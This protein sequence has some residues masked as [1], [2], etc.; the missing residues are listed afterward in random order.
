MSYSGCNCLITGGLGFLGSNLAHALVARGARVTVIDNFLPLHGANLFNI[1]GIE[2]KIKVVKADIR[3]CP[4]L[5]DIVKE[6]E[7]IFNLA[8]QVSHL[9]SI[10]EPFTDYEINVLGNL[11]ILEACRNAGNSVRII[12]AGT[13]SQY[14]EVKK[15]PV[16][17][18]TQRLPLDIYSV[19][20]DTAE[21]LHFIYGALFGLR[22][23]SLRINN[24]FGPY[25]QMQ[26]HRY[27]ILNWFIRIALEDKELKV[28]GDGAQLRDY[29]FVDDITAAFLIAGE[30]KEAEGEVYNT[31]SGN[32]LKFGEMA[33]KIVKIAGAGRI[34]TVP[35][36]EGYKNI[37][38]GNYRVNI[39]K[40]KALGWKP[41]SD[42]E[43]GLKKTIEFYRKYKNYYW[44]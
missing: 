7:V 20:K 10:S 30:K 39:S 26:H 31:G 22:V 38:V 23:T 40:L 19:H 44:K 37:E 29:S 25:H 34:K 33:K 16:Y 28:F 21:R 9:D 35:W 17:E 15:L 12:Y 1:N 24:V 8:A 2:D 18:N 42:F 43:K 4:K 32:S 36:P 41:Q 11:K 6:N 13:R 27:G 14:G 3:N 5:P